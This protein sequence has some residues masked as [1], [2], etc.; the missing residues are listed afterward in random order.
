MTG[1]QTCALPILREAG[2]TADE[3][4]GAAAHAGGLMPAPL[5]MN[6]SDIAAL[7]ATGAYGIPAPR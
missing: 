2:A 3:I 4:I 5:R 7:F 6:V 1:V